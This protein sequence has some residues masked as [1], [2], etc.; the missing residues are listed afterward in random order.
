M[1]T[2]HV[3]LLTVGKRIAYILLVFSLLLVQFSGLHLHLCHGEE[4]SIGHPSAHYADDGLLFGED[5][6]EDDSDDIE[7]SFPGSTFSSSSQTLNHT[8]FSF[9][10]TWVLYEIPAVESPA[11]SVATVAFRAQPQ[12]PLPSWSPDLPPARG[13]PSNS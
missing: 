12:V 7:S 11:T 9:D 4:N 10:F 1:R 3:I 13:P 8:D 2:S 5:H 6:P